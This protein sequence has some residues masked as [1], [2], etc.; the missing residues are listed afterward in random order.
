MK[1]V[2]IASL[3]FGLLMSSSAVAGKDAEAAA[4]RL[5][6]AMDMQAV[7]DASL[8]ASLNAKL[9]QNPELAPYRDVF[10]GFFAKYMSYEALKP[11]LA[12]VYAE[13][14]SAA[15]LDAAA[16]FYSTPT[17]KRFLVKLPILFNKGVEIGQQA[18]AEH[19]PELQEAVEAESRRLQN[20]TTDGAAG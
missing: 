2:C 13:E 4:T 6:D 14:F 19:L 8:D 9:S 5:L 11:K 18:V 15:E 3:M 7:L 12:A 17:G 16:A 20:A 1:I 10:L